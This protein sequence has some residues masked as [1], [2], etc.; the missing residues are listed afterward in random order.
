[1]S[2]HGCVGTDV[3]RCVGI[4]VGNCVGIGVGSCVGIDVGGR[5]NDRLYVIVYS[6]L[7]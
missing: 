7:S 1:M 4:G 2:E 5:V 3:G 6:G